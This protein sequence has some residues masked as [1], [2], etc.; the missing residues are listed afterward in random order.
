VL[1]LYVLV[2]RLLELVLL[3]ARGD[4]APDVEILLPRHRGVPIR[5]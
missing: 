4:R 1:A 3:F 5:T 2:S